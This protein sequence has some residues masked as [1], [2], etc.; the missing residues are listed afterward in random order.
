LLHRDEP[1][2]APAGWGGPR[3]AGR[4]R[5]ARHGRT[6]ALE[7]DDEAPAPAWATPQA[8]RAAIG[9]VVHHESFGRGVVTGAE[10]AGEDMKFTVRFRIGTKKVLGRFL[11]DGADGDGA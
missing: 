6:H 3:F 1:A 4:E 10:G 9:R 11:A 7:I 8:V 5:P 2:R